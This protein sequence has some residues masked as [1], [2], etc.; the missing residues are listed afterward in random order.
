M[1]FLYIYSLPF[2][3]VELHKK[4]KINCQELFSFEF[5]YSKTKCHPFFPLNFCSGCKNEIP[6][7]KTVSD[8][9]F[10]YKLK[11][12]LFVSLIY[13]IRMYRLITYDNNVIFS[14]SSLLNYIQI[15]RNRLT[16]K[17]F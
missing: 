17:N 9:N 12:N 6:R 15:K 8:L 2:V 13:E 3:K 5:K 16:Y 11:K 1:L 4:A 7:Y 10:F 14:F